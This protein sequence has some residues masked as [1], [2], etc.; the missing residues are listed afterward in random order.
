[1][2]QLLLLG[3]DEGGLVLGGEGGFGRLR[4][5]TGASGH[6]S[7]HFDPGPFPPYWLQLMALSHGLTVLGLWGCESVDDGICKGTL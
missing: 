3:S 1:M 5:W 6:P 7:P 4:F 2:Q